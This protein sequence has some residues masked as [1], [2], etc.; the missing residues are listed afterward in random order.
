ML[1]GTV[2]GLLFAAVATSGPVPL[3]DRAPTFLDDVEV[4]RPAEPIV[5]G[6][7]RAE[8]TEREPWEMPAEVETVLR[9]IVTVLLVA[10]AA[11]ALH[12]L[13]R[14][15]PTLRWRRRHRPPTDGLEVLPDVVGSLSA[16]AEAQR[17]ALRRG[18]PRNA[19][20]ECWLRL[21]AT[22][23][24]A[25][26]EPDPA[27]TSDELTRRV[28]ARH[29]VDP[30]ALDEL[31]ALYR[32]ARFSDHQMGEPSRQRAIEALDAVHADLATRG[33]RRR[34]RVTS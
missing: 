3:A 27:E 16:D 29:R 17:A 1:V 13:W 19:I 22:V 32:E 7:A 4:D 14:D 30:G 28:L 31:A 24:A 12:R 18:A 6:P 26:V 10:A 2:V 9:T 11:V 15:R 33:S 5:L 25:G 21:E 34:T 8:E 20:V 23:A